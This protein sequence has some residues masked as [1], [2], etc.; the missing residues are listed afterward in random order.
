MGAQ[1]ALSQ[2]NSIYWNTQHEIR[3]SPRI[4]DPFFHDFKRNLLQKGWKQPESENITIKSQMIGS[5]YQNK[6]E[7]SESKARIQILKKPRQHLLTIGLKISNSGIFVSWQ[8]RLNPKLGKYLGIITLIVM[9]LSSIFRLSLP[10]ESMTPLVFFTIGILVNLAILLTYIM[11][12]EKEIQANDKVAI[13]F[14]E[15]LMQYEK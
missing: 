1:W 14:I 3:I 4:A 6:F 15:T 11:L 7:E 5:K 13:A 12:F 8:E 10:I 9:I 2:Y